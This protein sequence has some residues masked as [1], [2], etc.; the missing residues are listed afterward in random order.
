MSVESCVY[1]P[2]DDIVPIGKINR[3][4]FFFNFGEAITIDKSGKTIRKYGKELECIQYYGEFDLFENNESI[5]TLKARSYCELFVLRRDVFEQ[6][7]SFLLTE[8]EILHMSE[9][10]EKMK[11]QQKKINK[12][13]GEVEDHEYK[14]WKRIFLP[15][16]MFRNIWGTI[17]MLLLLFMITS[18]PIRAS[19]FF[20]TSLTPS[21]ITLIAF[22]VLY[23]LLYIADIILSSLFFAY[24][25]NG[26][27]VCVRRE[28]KQKY[29]SNRTFIIDIFSVVPFEYITIFFDIRYFAVIRLVKLVRAIHLFETVAS[30]DAFL[31]Y[32]EISLNNTVKTLFKY[33][34]V[35]LLFSIY[36]A[37]G[38][39]II[40]S[41]FQNVYH[42]RYKTWVISDNENESFD[43]DHNDWNGS[44]RYFRS[45]YFVIVGVT[46]VGYG[47]ITPKNTYETFYTAIF[48]LIG[49][50][51]YPAIIGSLASLMMELNA[52]RKNF[53]HKTAV[54][55]KYMEMK[56]YTMPL[57]DRIIRFYDYIWS[58]Q[59]GID[60]ISILKDLSA[61]LRTSAL[62][63]VISNSFKRVSFFSNV[64]SDCIKSLYQTVE[65]TIFLPN[66]IILGYGELGNALYFLEHGLARIISESRD[67]PESLENMLS[68]NKSD[69][70]I[71]YRDEDEAIDMKTSITYRVLYPGSYIGEG[72]LIGYTSLTTVIS[73]TFSDCF[74]LQKENFD[75]VL[76]EYSKSKVKILEGIKRVYVNR[77]AMF[78]SINKNLG[79]KDKIYKSI[80]SA[81]IK[82][83]DIP[84][85]S[86]AHPDSRKRRLWII[87]CLA[88]VLYYIFAIPMKI[89]VF[90]DI[91]IYYTF[92]DWSLDII[93]IMD[94]LLKLFYFGYMYEGQL[95]FD[96]NDIYNNYKSDKMFVI[97]CIASVP[98]EIFS[99]F[100]I[101][102]GYNSNDVVNLWMPIL[103]LPKLLYAIHYNE[104]FEALSRLVEDF[105]FIPEAVPRL[106]ELFCAVLVTAHIFACGFFFLGIY[107]NDFTYK[108]NYCLERFDKYN[109]TLNH[110][111]L[112]EYADC[113]YKNSW[114]QNQI[115]RGFLAYNGDLTT[116][117][118]MRAFYWAISTLIC[119]VIGDATPTNKIETIYAIFT[120]FVGVII[121]SAIIGGI[122]DLA[123]KQQG[124]DA[125]LKSQIDD[126]LLYLDAQAVP[127]KLKEKV[128]KY[129][130]Y[131]LH[132]T[133]GYNEKEILEDL[134][135]TLRT[136]VLLEKRQSYIASCPI[137]KNL[138]KQF[139]KAL[140]LY[141]NP[142]V[143]SPKEVVFY[144]GETLKSMYFI[145]NG[146]INL[147]FERMLDESSEPYFVLTNNYYFGEMYMFFCDNAMDTAESQE[148]T[149]ILELKKTDLIT[150]IA[151][152]EVDEN[153][154]F[155]NL[156][157]QPNFLG[158][159]ANAYKQ[160]SEMNAHKKSYSFKVNKTISNVPVKKHKIISSDS[161]FFIAWNV[162]GILLLIFYLITIMYFIAFNDPLFMK[163]YKTAFINY[164]FIYVIDF[165]G[166]I[167]YVI[168]IYIRLNHL[169]YLDK[170]QTISNPHKIR[171]RYI[172]N[173]LVFDVLA[174]VPI[175]IISL[176]R[177][178]LYPVLRLHL[179]FHVYRYIDYFSVIS[180]AVVK[181]T[182]SVS[183]GSI[184]IFNVF[185]LFILY[186]HN[187]A[188]IHFI[189]HRYFIPY[190]EKTTFIG[191]GL[192][193]FDPITGLHNIKNDDIPFMQVYFTAFYFTMNTMTTVGFGDYPPYHPC[194]IIISIFL[195][196]IAAS[197]Q[198]L[199]CGIIGAYYTAKDSSGDASFKQ[200]IHQI[201]EYLDFRKVPENL[202]SS[203]NY[204]FKFLWKKDKGM[205]KPDAIEKLPEPLKMDIMH[206]LYIDSFKII[207]DLSS[208]PIDVQR[209]ISLKIKPYFCG[210][211]V[212]IYNIGDLSVDVYMIDSGLVVIGSKSGKRIELREGS[213]FGITNEIVRSSYAKTLTPCELL[214]IEK[215]DLIEIGKNYPKLMTTSIFEPLNLA[216]PRSFI[217]NEIK[218]MSDDNIDASIKNISDSEAEGI[219]EPL[220]NFAIKRKLYKK[221]NGGSKY[222]EYLSDKQKENVKS[223][224][225]RSSLFN[226]IQR[227]DLTKSN[228]QRVLKHLVSSS[229]VMNNSL[230]SIK[231][232]E[233]MLGKDFPKFVSP[234]SPEHRTQS[235][236][237]QSNLR[238]KMNNK[239]NSSENES[240]SEYSQGELVDQNLRPIENDNGETLKSKGKK[241]KVKD[242]H[243]NEDFLE[244]SNISFKSDII[245]TSSVIME[246]KRKSLGTNCLNGSDDKDSSQLD[247]IS[248]RNFNGLGTA[249]T[250]KNIFRY[251]TGTSENDPIS[252]IKKP[253]FPRISLQKAE[254][255]ESPETM[256][257][258]NN[259][260]VLKTVSSSFT[261]KEEK[262]K[263]KEEEEKEEKK[264]RTVFS[265]ENLE[266]MT[267]D[268]NAEFKE[269]IKAIMPKDKKD[270]F[271]DLMVDEEVLSE[272]ESVLSPTNNK[273]IKKRIIKKKKKIIKKKVPVII[274]DEID[275]NKEIDISKEDIESDYV[276]TNIPRDGE[277][278]ISKT[279]DIVKEVEAVIIRDNNILESEGEKIN[280][281]IEI[282]SETIVVEHK[283]KKR[284]KKKKIIKR[285]K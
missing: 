129:M 160:I 136:D 101:A 147:Y 37:S 210:E 204:Y 182:Q 38:M 283:V 128:A 200:K 102:Y 250:P 145:V 109:T 28:I 137:F 234:L 85:D 188:C 151:M 240:D 253:K 247:S 47:D 70:S 167:Y 183:I 97:D 172:K 123:A 50:I 185:A 91:S 206:Q 58:R 194:E 44:V 148:F 26:L 36:A 174:L 89:V 196:I 251:S 64:E 96:S 65:P 59:H 140:A 237:R 22:D 252:I 133:Q 113:L 63:Y 25:V 239:P 49:G 235:N 226:I 192:S 27:N 258:F 162:I 149:E 118:Y 18:I 51:M 190:A 83:Q 197:F 23:D 193:T 263:E 168:D 211:D 66:D 116:M 135:V 115:Q 264:L 143:F 127:D 93:M 131:I 221:V 61:P 122:A 104:N 106:L 201:N 223:T 141:L 5:Y 232:S 179:F 249:L 86:F 30:F 146:V 7:R 244:N 138:N 41:I 171:Q 79:C 11:K 216:I 107:G 84:V 90:V 217:E 236:L 245:A 10:L 117:Q 189:I 99:V 166:F 187:S 242:F 261:K 20:Y 72:S 178:D 108:F 275:I 98:Y 48:V 119:V 285:L 8:D 94:L 219:N 214:I 13:F 158:Q 6:I 155:T 12:I 75:Q 159:S 29:F 271:S 224:L 82:Q 4:L 81:E 53:K 202:K 284:I 134:P 60:E 142:I 112:N 282:P 254:I 45:I 100:F 114:I 39:L 55:R 78:E 31:S 157:E 248:N 195:N 110:F 2:G 265:T 165:L 267:P 67:L 199:L 269:F 74:V 3:D 34:S 231:S 257:T 17:L 273:K 35:L 180:T 277:I 262:E 164:T 169:S 268:N 233:Q 205:I 24:S 255:I 71:N 42:G 241:Y 281:E 16:S 203:I 21:V 68:V 111:H 54:V 14:G 150:F 95:Y 52:T 19:Y 62:E 88:I 278:L 276:E 1:S 215:E 103:R 32:Y 170:G 280:Q 266:N 80:G 260:S 256:M 207:K 218:N 126:L 177:A 92:I 213:T 259:F 153:Q 222:S 184:K 154:I 9:L 230:M 130:D 181:L 40:G 105:S 243:M 176:Y 212:F 120:M 272:K 77:K 139:Y 152:L 198:A 73:I 46:T 121:N 156:S 173:G 279:T 69:T 125:E 163:Q 124:E 186:V 161:E 175:E 76:E 270:T 132:S 208:V 220:E 274:S 229:N 246:N 43:I 227:K 56:S 144:K 225:R 57:T 238:I 87:M 228:T 33:I 209:Q 15:H 191:R